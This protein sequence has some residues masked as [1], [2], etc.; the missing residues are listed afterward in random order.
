M[1]R[2]PM[3]IA[4]GEAIETAIAGFTP[5]PDHRDSAVAIRVRTLMPD[6]EYAESSWVG[7]FTFP[8]ANKIIDKLVDLLDGH[9]DWHPNA[10]P[11]YSAL[12]VHGRRAEKTSIIYGDPYHNRYN[13]STWTEKLYALAQAGGH[14][15]A[16]QDEIVRSMMDELR[17][18]VDRRL[19]EGAYWTPVTATF[20][21]PI[22]GSP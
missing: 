11:R 15:P 16:R 8:D 5:A 18:E 1:S 3:L 22:G 19:P 7:R 10:N 13:W 17:R 9:C 20:T 6:R 12:V 4:A 2:H 14:T 21:V